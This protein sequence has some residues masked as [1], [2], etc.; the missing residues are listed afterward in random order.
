MSGVGIFAQILHSS[1][2]LHI[3]KFKMIMISIMLCS[4]ALVVHFL[5]VIWCN[6][7]VFW[8]LAVFLERMSFILGQTL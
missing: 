2:H 6:C 4:V 8:A 3:N 1:V 7:F 5:A